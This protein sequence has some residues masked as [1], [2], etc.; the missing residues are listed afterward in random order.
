MQQNLRTPSVSKPSLLF[1]YLLFTDSYFSKVF[2]LK[3]DRIEVLYMGARQIEW[4]SI[5]NWFKE[6]LM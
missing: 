4:Y 6:S 1:H 3:Y 5:H 2:F